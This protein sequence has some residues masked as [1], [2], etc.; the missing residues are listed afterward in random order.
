ML[1]PCSIMCLLMGYT[2]ALRGLVPSRQGH[3][4][5]TALSLG[6]DL[7]A[8]LPMLSDPAVYIYPLTASAVTVAIALGFGS[9]DSK[10]GSPYDGN[11]EKYDVARA[12]A[13]YRSK[14]LFVFRR[15]LKL[16][17]STNAFL[18]KLALDWRRGSLE[19]NQAERAKEAL[20]LATQLGPT[21]IKLGQAL[22]IRTDL[23][24]EAYALE[25]RKLQDAV[26]PFDST[27]AKEIIRREMG[28]RNLG[29]VFKTLSDKP[30]ASASIGQVYRGTLLD[31]RDVAVKV[32]RPK[33]LGDIA[34]D[35][36][37]L[38][39]L[40][41]LQV[42]ASN[43]FSQRSTEQADID[44][45]LSLVDEWGRG[46]VAEVD[47]R[48]EALNTM[49]FIAAMERRGLNAV[50]APEVVGSLSGPRVIVT[51]WMDGT[52]LDRDASSDVPRLCSVAVNAYLTMLLD[53]GVLHCDP[54]PGNLLRTTDGRLCILDWGMT[55]RVPPDLQYS[56]L[57]FIAHINTEDYDS[58]LV[59]FINLVSL[60]TGKYNF[61]VT[62]ALLRVSHLPTRS[63]SSGRAV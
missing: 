30:I 6:L 27:E 9:D 34:L 24:P 5:S 19:G 54:H 16:A 20:A 21:F 10:L 32:Q 40:T 50:T 4:T 55:L 33:I 52:R 49:E 56:L 51:R 37:I 28:V 11:Q 35:L 44:V 61:I 39:L 38:R 23:I 45:A 25:L 1:N 3:L 18:L 2:R 63:T 26:P 17:G 29:E 59:D 48:L 60:Y 42:R 57:E 41:P 43:L 31:G 58:L 14:P 13:F 53:T 47:Y 22:S 62:S 8:S 46:F 15:L 12:D 36:F 7:D